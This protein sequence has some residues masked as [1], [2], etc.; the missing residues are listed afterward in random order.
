MITFLTTAE[1]NYTITKYSELW[2]ASL[3][4][5]I[6]SLS[7]ELLFCMGSIPKGT[8]IFTD[9]DRLAPKNLIRAGQWYQIMQDHGVT[10]LN[11]PRRYVGRFALLQRLYRDGRNRFSAYSLDERHLAKFPVFLRFAS[12]HGGPESELLHNAESLDSEIGKAANRRSKR[13]LIVVEYLDHKEDDDRHYKYSHF[14]IGKQL[15]FAGM[16][17]GKSWCLKGVEDIDDDIV[18]R[19][20][21]HSLCRDNDESLMS[22]FE[23]AGVEFGRI[24][25]AIVDGQ[26][27]VFEIN[28]NPDLGV[29]CLPGLQRWLVRSRCYQEFNEILWGYHQTSSREGQITTPGVIRPGS[30]LLLL[31]L[32]LWRPV[33]QLRQLHILRTQPTRKFVLPWL[34]KSWMKRRGKRM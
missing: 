18:E 12:G 29:A 27:Q 20:R 7:Y 1:H 21:N 25:Y 2:G 13:E 33:R 14:R 8:Y 11:D 15:I 6:R 26:V 24:D 23:M 34:V 5:G 30:L 32:T 19:E 10:V 17:C 28:T 9:L 16:V 3:K 31:L 22:C 4:Q